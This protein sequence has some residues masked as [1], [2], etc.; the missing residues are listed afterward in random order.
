[1]KN[2]TFSLKDYVPVKDFK[3]RAHHTNKVT[4]W[5]HTSKPNLKVVVKTLNKS[6]INRDDL[7]QNNLRTI[8]AFFGAETACLLEN[9]EGLVMKFFEGDTLS[10]EE[11]EALINKDTSPL[12]TLTRNGVKFTMLDPNKDNFLKLET[13]E[14]IPVDFDYMIM[15]DNTEL[16]DYQKDYLN[17]RVGFARRVSDCTREE[18]VEYVLSSYPAARNYYEFQKWSTKYI[19]AEDPYAELLEQLADDL[20]DKLLIQKNHIS[21]QRPPFSENNDL[22]VCKSDIRFSQAEGTHFIITPNP[23]LSDWFESCPL[24][25]TVSLN[26]SLQGF[27]VNKETVGINTGPS[28]P[29]IQLKKQGTNFLVCNNITADNRMKGVSAR[30]E[31]LKNTLSELTKYVAA[32]AEKLVI[33][34]EAISPK[35]DDVKIKLG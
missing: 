21:E 31:H 11:E 26:G 13:G 9:G 6:H 7:I 17:Y 3:T 1:M 2:N 33:K 28:T 15:H 35:D 22:F 12:R 5:Q 27:K 19:G 25:Q 24:K 14:I 18:G 4:L 20:T 29:G 30:E 10:P 16:L 23:S 32:N 8:N 34:E